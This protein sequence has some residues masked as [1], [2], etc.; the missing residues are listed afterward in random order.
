MQLHQ[1]FVPVIFKKKTEQKQKHTHVDIP[2]HVKIEND[3][4]GELLCAPKVPL[5]IGILIQ[6]RRIEMG[7]KQ[8]ELAQ[9]INVKPQEIQQFESCKTMPD[10]NTL[11]KLR[12]VLNCQIKIKSN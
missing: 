8:T 6:Q 9:K 3:N 4:T 7:L 12:R 5:S 11:Q 2:R 10:N 1:D